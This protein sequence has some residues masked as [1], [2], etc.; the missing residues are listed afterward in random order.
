MNFK[1]H[2][3]L[4]AALV[5]VPAIAVGEPESVPPEDPVQLRFQLDDPLTYDVHSRLHIEYPERPDL[6][7]HYE[8]SFVVDYEPLTETGRA[9][10][11]SWAMNVGENDV[12]PADGFPV[13]ATV[14]GFSARFDHPPALTDPG[15]HYQLLRQATFSYRLGARGGVSDV[16]VHPPTNPVIRTSVEELVRLLAVSHPPFPDHS[17]EPGERWSDTAKLSMG[18]DDFEITQQLNAEYHFTR[19]IPCRDG[20]CALIDVE[21]DLDARARYA[22][23]RLVTHTESEGTARGRLLFDPDRGHLVDARWEIDLTGHTHTKRHTDDAT[24]TTVEV[25][26][27]LDVETT[28]KLSDR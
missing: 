24:E 25:P 9:L 22:V 14:S 16:R 7:P 5:F 13:V 1:F 20:Y 10:L 18:V 2:H 6:H 4:I 15:L 19:W 8:S 26:F 12:D 11:P 17:V 23:G 3:W 21:Q 28:F 27:E